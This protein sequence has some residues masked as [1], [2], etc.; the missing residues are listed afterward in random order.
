MSSFTIWDCI[1]P[2]KKDKLGTQDVENLVDKK[3]N[4]SLADISYDDHFPEI[5][6]KVNLFFI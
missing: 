2:I 3:M 4:P 5:K 1:P 6:K